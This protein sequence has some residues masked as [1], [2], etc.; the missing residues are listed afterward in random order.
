MIIY[1]FDGRSCKF[2]DKLSKTI[3]ESIK[4]GLPYTLACQA[5][6]ID[7]TTYSNWIKK[8]EKGKDDM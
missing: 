2:N 3:C 7:Y 1:I 6:S 4:Q 8:C 5:A